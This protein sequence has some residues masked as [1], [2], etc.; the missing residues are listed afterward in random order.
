MITF[1]EWITQFKEEPGVLGAV[2]CD[3][4]DDSSCFPDQILDELFLL[5]WLKENWD[6]DSHV[7]NQVIQAYRLY[8]KE[9]L[10]L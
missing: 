1:A 2:A 8:R 6:D 3:I 10:C 4:E 5:N 7:I 9:V